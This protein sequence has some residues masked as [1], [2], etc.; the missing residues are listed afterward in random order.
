METQL[1]DNVTIKVKRLVSNA[2]TIEDLKP[3]TDGSIG[4]D[5]VAIDHYY[6]K[7]HKYHEYGTGIAIQIPEGYEAQL[8]PRSSIRKSSLVLVN[9]PATIDRDY[10][11]E[12]IV[13]FK[14]IDD[15]EDIYSVGD[16]VAQLVI[17][18]VP[19]VTFVEV[20]ELDSTERGSGGFGS[21]GK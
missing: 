21:T 3:K 14:E 1:V 8:R 17:A 5:L 18:P 9:S 10:T 7:D 16:R 6:D 2:Q 13:T 12:L 11:G 15:R 19:K 20:S 4:I